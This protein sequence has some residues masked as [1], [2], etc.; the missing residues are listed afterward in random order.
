MTAAADTNSQP[1]V[2]L[3]MRA[4]TIFGVCEAIGED[5]GISPAWLRIPL[6]GSVLYSPFGAIAI[7]LALGVLVLGS[8]LLFP[9]TTASILA[10]AVMN[11]AANSQADVKLA[12]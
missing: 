11:D 2:A 4:H 9:R 5:F 7:Y 12:A 3:P 6:A 10:N 1:Y 8:R